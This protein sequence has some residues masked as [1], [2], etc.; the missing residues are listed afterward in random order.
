MMP[1]LSGGGGGGGGG[2]RDELTHLDITAHPAG[3]CSYYPWI[4]CEFTGASD[5][6]TALILLPSVRDVIV[7]LDTLN[8]I[9]QMPGER[10]G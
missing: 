7:S 10:I 9:A 3:K 6:Y 5:G 1:I 4:I 8:Y 2:G